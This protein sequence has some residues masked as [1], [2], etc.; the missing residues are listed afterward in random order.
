M[1]LG[2]TQPLTELSTKNLI[3]VMGD[4]RVRL[5]TSPPSV[6]RLSKKC[7][8]VDISQTYGPPWPVAAV[9]LPFSIYVVI[10]STI[11]NSS[12]IYLCFLNHSQHEM[13]ALKFY[14]PDWWRQFIVIRCCL[15]S[16]CSLSLPPIPGLLFW[17]L[18]VVSSSLC[19]SR[20]WRASTAVKSLHLLNYVLP[21]LY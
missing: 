1:V 2:S 12:D 6:S 4:R 11:I 8:N 20:G 21:L 10:L 14:L 17:Y 5:K 16:K 7:G 19:M 18:F 9:P 15:L 3:G 13:Y